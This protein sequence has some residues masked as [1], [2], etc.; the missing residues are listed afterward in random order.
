MPFS[1]HREAQAWRS[2]FVNDASDH[3]N[4]I[5][6]ALGNVRVGFDVAAATRKDKAKVAARTNQLPFPDRVEH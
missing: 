6:T 2:A 5:E 4:G 1:I 3:L